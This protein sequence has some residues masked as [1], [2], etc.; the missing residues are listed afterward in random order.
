[1]LIPP[2]AVLA[3]DLATCPDGWKFYSKAEGRVILGVGHGKDLSP[4]TLGEEGGLERV[5]LSIPEM[6]SHYHLVASKDG[7][8]LEEIFAVQ[9]VGKGEFGGRHSRQTDLR[10][11]DQAHENM[12][13]FVALRYCIKCETLT[14]CLP[15]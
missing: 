13:P 10:G 5:R 8:S 11:G 2:S 9:A 14:D 12:P 15:R 1:M 7:G 4:R 3:F 6:P